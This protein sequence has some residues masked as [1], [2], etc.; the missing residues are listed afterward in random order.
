[1]IMYMLRHASERAM[2]ET[3]KQMLKPEISVGKFKYNF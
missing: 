2:I 1:M 3:E